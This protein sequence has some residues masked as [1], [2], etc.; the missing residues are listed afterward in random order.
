MKQFSPHFFNSQLIGK[1]KWALQDT[2]LRSKVPRDES[3]ISK[4]FLQLL[5]SVPH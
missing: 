3:H 2:K 4:V 5:T 1:K